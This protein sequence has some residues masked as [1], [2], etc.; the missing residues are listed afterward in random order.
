MLLVI[1][2]DDGRRNIVS[3]TLQCLSV[4]LSSVSVVFIVR[5]PAVSVK[6]A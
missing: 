1:K 6:I 4:S 3:F 5:H 2:D